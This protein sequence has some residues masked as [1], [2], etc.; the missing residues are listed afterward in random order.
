MLRKHDRVKYI[1]LEVI[2]SIEQIHSHPACDLCGADIATHGKCVASGELDLPEIRVHLHTFMCRKCRFV[3]QRERFSE[4]LLSDLYQ[5][6]TSYD[7]GI[8][9]DEVAK[10]QAGLVERQAVISTAMSA[11]GIQARASVLDIGGGRGECC[12]HLVPMHRVVVADATP[13]PPV[14]PRIEKIP[15][16]FTSDIG[17][18]TFEVVVMN[19]V[20]EHVFSPSEL[21]AG[22]HQ[23]MKDRG[24]LIVEVPFELYT[25]LVFRH[26]GDW[27]HVGYFSRHT[28]L[29]FLEK[30]GFSVQRLTLEMGAYGARRLPVIRAVARKE[31]DAALSVGNRRGHIAPLLAD[32]AS[33]VV[34]ASLVERALGR[35]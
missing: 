18:G 9:T 5:S 20:L 28:L 19:H 25:P 31:P 4:A 33:P 12:K 22:A 21:L 23:A 11:S 26:L 16:L 3:F 34:L 8:R 13:E 30:S 32:M 7:F 10:V 6:D 14:D 24:T 2:N 15:G 35:S 1:G 27:R 17:A 29:R